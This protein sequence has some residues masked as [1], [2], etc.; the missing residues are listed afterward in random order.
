MSSSD[1]IVNGF[2]DQM[3]GEIQKKILFEIRSQRLDNTYEAIAKF[4]SE[5]DV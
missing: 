2:K 4:I 1:L 3:L 5:I